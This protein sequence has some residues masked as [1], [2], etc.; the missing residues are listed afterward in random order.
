[1]DKLF[2][3][4]VGGFFGAVARFGLLGLVKKI[5]G[6]SF[7]VSTL[8]VNVIGC[9]AIGLVMALIDT[10]QLFSPNARLFITLG[11]LGSFTTFSTVGYETFALMRD[12]AW[13]LT[14]LNIALN[15]TLG[16]AAVGLGWIA[17]KAA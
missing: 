8:V 12:G 11:L 4:G 15:V 2:I 14:I 1:M 13:L 3:I 6:D 5:A 10:R 9:L 7:P 17:V 16:V